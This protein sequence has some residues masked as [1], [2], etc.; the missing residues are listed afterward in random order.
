LGKAQSSTC[1]VQTIDS[2]S[3][4]E[5]IKTAQQRGT[6]T[7]TIENALASRTETPKI[8]QFMDLWTDYV[9]QVSK[10][11]PSSLGW[12]QSA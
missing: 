1:T 6:Y 3:W 2:A 8:D 5:I 10:Q 9:Q 12:G 4:N 7:N 11:Q